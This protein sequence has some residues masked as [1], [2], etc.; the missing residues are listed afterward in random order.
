MSLTVQD[1]R[2]G[3]AALGRGNLQTDQDNAAI[4]RGGKGTWIKSFLNIGG[5]RQANAR[6]LEALRLAV[7]SDP[8]YARVTG[9]A[10]AL[11]G[12]MDSRSPLTGKK[13]AL[14]LAQM[15]AAAQKADSDLVAHNRA[16]VSNMAMREMHSVD[17]QA[18]EQAAALGRQDFTLGAADRDKLNAMISERIIRSAGDFRETP[19]AEDI[20]NIVR[21]AVNRFVQ[22]QTLLDQTDLPPNIKNIIKGQ[23]IEGEEFISPERLETMIQIRQNLRNNAELKQTLTDVSGSD[24]PLRA[25]LAPAMAEAGMGEAVSGP[26]LEGL[27]GAIG[28]AIDKAGNM[29]RHPVSREEGEAIV[30]GC[31]RTFIE[32]FQAAGSLSNAGEAGFLQ[33][34][35]RTS[36]VLITPAYAQALSERA[37]DIPPEAFAALAGASTPEKMLEALENIGQILTRGFSTL[38]ASL[39]GEGAEGR[40]TY[41]EHSL[42]LALAHM[43]MSAD[44]A[45]ALF[46]GLNTPFGREMRDMLNFASASDP[47]MG[48][49][50]VTLLTVMQVL[51]QRAGADVEAFMEAE[52]LRPFPA[53]AERLPLEMRSRLP[54]FQPV[55]GNIPLTRPADPAE[56]AQAARQSF[57]AQMEHNIQI[58]MK[59]HT[60][61]LAGGGALPAYEKDVVRD[62]ILM[63]VG[64][65]TLPQTHEISE[66]S[67]RLEGEGPLGKDEAAR[68]AKQAVMN[69]GYNAMARLAT[70][71]EDA[72]FSELEAPERTKALILTSLAN[73]ETEKTS[74]GHCLRM[75]APDYENG[76]PQGFS[77]SL[78]LGGEGNRRM[79]FDRTPDGDFVVRTHGGFSPTAIV[80]NSGYLT[81]LNP[82]SDISA[83]STLVI[84]R[85]E[86]E[87]LSRLDWNLT[88][89][90]LRSPST[91]PDE[92]QIHFSEVNLEDE[93]R[94]FGRE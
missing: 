21:E 26:A 87:R 45:R 61:R 71:R 55:S 25:A 59:H 73:Q 60:D 82:R 48:S 57:A 11:L 30:A 52:R 50:S 24:S 4:V 9:Q 69:N 44:R 41:I 91:L 39:R 86:M 3:S 22:L 88:D 78:P 66:E 36:P 76:S 15:D 47:V 37:G 67:L 65:T 10:D 31:V 33:N 84:S 94:L 14:F 32:A 12:R 49:R 13:V 62:G 75:Q 8:R 54:G 43:G 83:S 53:N 35:V 38:D 58:Q 89:E 2:A 34:L 40:V 64:G 7:H 68:R 1:F 20:R 77:F 51:G 92:Y 90:Q 56:A 42:G 70:G 63:T 19:R 28:K 72:L 6:T 46:D 93:M 81:V 27:S 16:L 74:F 80:Y 18:A 79:D 5:A 29:G 85:D 23:F 17:R